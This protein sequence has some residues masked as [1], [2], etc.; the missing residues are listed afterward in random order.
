MTTFT[1][2]EISPKIRHYTIENNEVTIYFNWI[3]NEA[4]DEVKK[5]QETFQLDEN[6]IENIKNFL[7]DEKTNKFIIL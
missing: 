6:I 1:L 4:D 3:Y 5:G 2:P 7:I